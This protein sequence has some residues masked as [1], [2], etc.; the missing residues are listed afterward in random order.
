[1]TSPMRAPRGKAVG[2]VQLFIPLAVI[3]SLVATTLPVSA[4]AHEPVDETTWL[5]AQR[6]LTGALQL[7]LG[8]DFTATPTEGV[9]PLEVDFVDRSEG[10]PESWLWDFGDGETSRLQHP[11]HTYQEVGLYSVGL[12]IAKSETSETRYKPWYIGVGFPDVGPGH[13]AFKQV[14]ACVEAG[15]VGGYPDGSY[16]PEYAVTRD[17]MAVYVARAMAGGDANVPSRPA[18]TTFSDVPIDDWAHKYVE[19][20]YARGVVEGFSATTYAPS[21]VVS[22]GQMAAYMAR[23][24]VAP[25]GDA[26]ILDPEPPATFPDAPSSLWAYKHIEYCVEHGVVRGY[27]D[28]YYRPEVVVARDQMAVYIARAFQLPV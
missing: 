18:A 19:Y 15:I 8:P 28:G 3:S 9:V 16:H 1:M 10:G 26:A 12:T 23:A 22:R 7:Y 14:L 6:N 20:C 5:L 21:Q 11:G 4:A 17:Q 2:L 24:I 13:W 27:E 25:A